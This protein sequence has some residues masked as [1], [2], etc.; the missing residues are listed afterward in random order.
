MKNYYLFWG[1]AEKDNGKWHPLICHILDVAAV[2]Q[3]WLEHDSALRILFLRL[4]EIEEC[5]MMPILT[6]A[7][8]F[9]DVG[10]ASVYFQNKN[11]ERAR[12]AGIFNEIAA[13]TRGFDHGA[14][15]C[16]WVDN[17]RIDDRNFRELGDRFP[18][19]LNESFAELWKAACWHHGKPFTSS[20]FHNMAPIDG[21]P[22]GG[23]T[24]YDK[25]ATMRSS[26]LEDVAVIVL[27]NG[28]SSMSHIPH[29]SPSMLKAFAGFVSVCDWIGSNEDYFPYQQAG[30]IAEYWKEVAVK[31]EK[32]IE[33]IF[34]TKTKDRSPVK[35]FKEIIGKERSP[36]P[37]Q[38]ALEST[39]C[40]GSTLLIVEAPTGEGKTE[41]ALFQFLRH[42]GRGFYFGLPTQASANQ[43]SGRVA[44]FLRKVVKTNEQAIL[45]H[46]DAWLVRLISEAESY[47]SDDDSMTDT[48]A[49]TELC[50]W[51]N[52]KKRSLLSRYGVGTVDQ[53]MLAA[54]NVKH[55]F[56]KLF[57]L[58]GKTLI[59]DEVH[60]YDSFMLPI[61]EH[62]LRWCGYLD[63]SVV[64]LS[65]T[66]PSSMKQGLIH[67]YLDSEEIKRS[68]WNGGYPL[69][70]IVERKTNSIDEIDSLHGNKIQ[71][72]KE[73][74]ISVSFATHQPDDINDIVDQT[75]LKIENGGNI[76]WICNTVKKAQFVYDACKRRIESQNTGIE[77]RLF[78]SRYT[79]RDR[80]AIEEEIENLYGDEKN[81]PLRP[82]RSVLV[83]TQVAEQSLDVDFDY[84][85]TD[86]APIDLIL[87]R[88]GRIF[89]H[90]RGNRSVF[91][92]SPEILVLIP[93]SVKEINN[94]ARVY[95][96]FTVL[97]TIV[98]LT[99][100]P[101]SIIKLPE[102]YRS[103][104]EKVYNDTIPEASR[105]KAGEI[106]L[107]L[108]RTIW[109]TILHDKREKAEKMN[110]RG[111]RGLTPHPANEHPAD[112]VLLN[113]DENSYWAAKTRDGEEKIGLILVSEREG[114]Y[115]AGESELVEA[116]PD[117]IPAG[118]MVQM[119]LNTVE[120][121]I[122]SLVKRIKRKECLHP[123]NTRISA[124]QAKI[125]RVPVLKGR[126][127]LLLNESGH[128]YIDC[129]DV[130]YTLS[131][132]IE[133]GLQVRIMK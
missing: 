30:D 34:H 76:L 82:K 126:K 43:I 13:S 46:G 111:H 57:G 130:T 54:L 87:Q 91:F 22:S 38:K 114:K 125:D 84:L 26:L 15:G 75:V 118:M 70:T 44:D 41:A 129:G 86:I 17:W 8:A 90:A 115:M 37:V 66:L 124:W 39:I 122:K 100:L 35:S 98:E 28:G 97:K 31:A 120:V 49:G 42:A 18:L 20:D 88:A 36:R 4:S 16:L 89:R 116:V 65:A 24:I 110:T 68:E 52:S 3:I 56:V 33:S 133:T 94:F 47:N 53:A 79:K 109:E 77:L 62:L 117:K 74:R 63:T 48:T 59:I 112:S 5:S 7:A 25:A 85:V 14:F 71:A 2:A 50:D 78:H 128:A 108:S 83:A 99:H 12:E 113:E 10:K 29:Q 72:R 64:L 103:L 123:D 131:Y 58:S 9:H 11:P 104:V 23:G 67:A 119:S 132:D 95:D 21:K 80:L 93:S 101:G 81:S 32:A 40:S 96:H 102:M 19:L 92:S 127:L 106:V 73:E 60:A 105:E 45:A 6:L 1:K 55:G 107:E 61:L 121:G 69:L 27:G 51:F